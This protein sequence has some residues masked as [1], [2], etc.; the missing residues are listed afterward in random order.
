MSRSDKSSA[1]L[2]NI[3]E[4]PFE[5]Q[6]SKKPDVKYLQTAPFYTIRSLLN[7]A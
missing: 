1:I 3:K 4:S 7:Q 2:L 5:A 6:Q